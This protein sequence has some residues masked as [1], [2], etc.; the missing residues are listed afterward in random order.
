M[1]GAS[2]GE[3]SPKLVGQKQEQN[4]DS[5]DG[6]WGEDG[7]TGGWSTAARHT[8]ELAGCW[9]EEEVWKKLELQLQSSRI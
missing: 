5:G 8:L 4:E 7:G 3:L 6:T 9:V 1:G 2:V